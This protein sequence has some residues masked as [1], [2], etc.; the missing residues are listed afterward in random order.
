VRK[1]NR[2]SALIAYLVPILGPLYAILVHRDKE[3][4]VFHAKQS[5]V[6]TITA[7]GAPVLWGVFAWVLLWVPTVGPLAAI[8]AFSLVILV[9]ILLAVDWILGMIN[10][11]RYELKPL[12][13]VG[14]WAERIPF[15]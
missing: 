3:F 8:A 1:M 14:R 9:Y 12:P 4:P 15:E 2:V 5:L 13:V 10:A 11:L 6:L 7:V